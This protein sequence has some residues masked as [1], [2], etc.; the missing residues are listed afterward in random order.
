MIRTYVGLMVMVAVALPVLSACTIT[1][2]VPPKPV[3]KLKQVGFSDV[4]GWQSDNQAESLA[5][6]V[7]S[8][9]RMMKMPPE[10]DLGI[11]GN[12][13]DWQAVC[14]NI[15]SAMT[16]DTA[17]QF[18]EMNF[19]PYLASNNGDEDGLFTGYYE[20]SLRGSSVQTGVY[21]TPIRARP[22]DLV[23]VN[24]G[25]FRP[26]LK[27]QRIAGRVN[28]SGQ[29]KPYENRTDI[30]TGKLPKDMDQPLYW[31]DSAVDAFFLQIQGSGVVT[32]PDGGAQR[33]GYDGQNGYPYT[34][35]GKELIAR[36]ALN[37][38]NVSMQTIRAW[39]AAHPDEA[40]DIMRSNQS[41]VFFKKLDT[42][43]PVGAEGLP[44]TP[45]RSMAVDHS[46]WPYGL[47]MFVNAAPP[48]DGAPAIHR[49]MVA[50]DT[51]GAII[52]VVRGDVFWG[53]GEK[54]AH[55]AGLMKSKGRLWVLLPKSVTPQLAE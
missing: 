22:S 4:A 29:L 54:A 18:Y 39:F 9:A 53:Y 47:P 48:E 13:R 28:D 23:M 49:L 37:K 11:A 16:T 44:L 38:E 45:E 55:N 24:L 52:G 46:I 2:G 8:C 26:E 14:A 5:A 33:I 34:A 15:P 27:G 20:A 21:Q 43:S 51:G 42:A 30:E 35:I 36:G 31:V 50:Q 25:D 1:E 10:K 3:L 6:F 41:Y 19:V 40:V 12:A 17:R 32:L 7:K